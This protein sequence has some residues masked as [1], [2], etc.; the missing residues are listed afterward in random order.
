[1]A[2]FAAAAILK[3]VGTGITAEPRAGPMAGHG[4]HFCKTEKGG[5]VKFKIAR[6]LGNTDR[7]L[8][9]GFSLLMIYFGFFSNY[10]ITDHVAGLLLGGMGIGLL[11]V[12]IIGVCPMYW[13]AGFSTYT[14]KT[15]A[16]R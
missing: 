16:A 10:L 15:D 2:V 7:I 12:A 1:M 8:R 4:C 6:N 3:V 11:L 14:G 13:L 9:I 5:F